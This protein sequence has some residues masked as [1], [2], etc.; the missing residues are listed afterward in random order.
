MGM[1]GLCSSVCRIDDHRLRFRGF[2]PCRNPRGTAEEFGRLRI[3]WAS[4]SFCL[5]GIEK[6]DW[7][8]TFVS[9]I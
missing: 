9:L 2:K 3:R 1:L 7:E 4:G 5:H 6:E 8:E